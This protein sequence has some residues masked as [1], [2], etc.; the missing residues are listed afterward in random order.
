MTRKSSP[1][2]KLWVTDQ[3][4]KGAERY[5]A[6]KSTWQ[7]RFY[8]AEYVWLH[9]LHMFQRD[10]PDPWTS[11]RTVHGHRRIWRG[12][13]EKDPWS[14]SISL[15]VVCLIW[16]KAPR[17][18]TNIK[19]KKRWFFFVRQNLAK[20]P[21]PNQVLNNKGLPSPLVQVLWLLFRDHDVN[22]I[23][24]PTIK[25]SSVWKGMTAGGV[26]SSKQSKCSKHHLGF[27][28]L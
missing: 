16:P 4:W 25:P 5:L 11:Q 2:W 17:Q 27:N 19:K 6:I 8:F 24:W 22:R 14:R 23:T 10:T 9:V 12:K 28:W 13:H 3:E 20:K 1:E 18:H 7:L 21:V 26:P 15:W